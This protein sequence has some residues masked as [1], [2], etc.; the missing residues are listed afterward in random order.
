MAS[1]YQG[2]KSSSINASHPQAEREITL[3]QIDSMY[4]NGEIG[5]QEAKKLVVQ[6]AVDTGNA[7]L[8]PSIIGGMK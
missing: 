4:S 3:T 5:V 8:L 6:W 7:T 2:F 1:S